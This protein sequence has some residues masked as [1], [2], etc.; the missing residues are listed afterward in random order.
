M[1]VE[2]CHREPYAALNAAR[3][4]LRSHG[5]RYA[6]LER[7]FPAVI[8][9]DPGRVQQMLPRWR[10]LSPRELRSCDGE[11]F[12]AAEFGPLSVELRET[13]GGAARAAFER[14]ARA[15]SADPDCKVAV[16]GL[17]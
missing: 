1:K 2:F 6:R 10:E 11:I 3:A 4:L 5:F 8:Y 9:Y 12:G 15:A 14:F 16:P 13:V 7:T 17:T